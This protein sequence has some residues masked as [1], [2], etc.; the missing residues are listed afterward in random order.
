MRSKKKGQG[1]VEF[2]LILPVLILVFFAIIDGAFVIQGLLTVNHA[3][4]QAARFA[5]TYQPVTG[6]C[7]EHFENGM[8]DDSVPW[9]PSGNDQNESDAAYYDRRTWLIKKYAREQAL[10]LRIQTDCTDSTNINACVAQ[11]V[12]GLFGTRVL[13]FMTF[14][15]AELAD[16]TLQNDSPGLPG[17]PVQVQ[18]VYHVPLTV[19]ATFLPDPYV[20]VVGTSEMINE[21]VQAGIGAVPPPVGGPAPLPNPND[22]PPPAGPTAT[23]GPTP[24]P[25]PTVDPSSPPDVV[26]IELNFETALNMLPQKREHLVI[27]TIKQ[28]GQPIAGMPIEFS[29]DKGSFDYSGSEIFQTEQLNTDADGK[30]RVMIYANEPMVANIMAWTDA[31]FNTIKEISEVDTAIKTWQ[32]TGP[33]LVASDHNPALEDVIA[34]AL[35]DHEP[36]Q[37][38][39]TL[40]WCTSNEAPAT[41]PL[42]L[43][44]TDN[45][46]VDNITWD[47]EITN[48]TVPSDAVG[49]YY[50]ESHSA[51]GACGATDWVARSAVIT[52]KEVMPDL[53]ILDVQVI[54]PAFTELAPG[55]W[56]TVAVEIQNLQP[57]SVTTGPFDVDVYPHLES[58]PYVMQL[59]AE[60]QWLDDLGPGATRVLTFVVAVQVVGANQLWAQIDTSNYVEEIDETNNVWGPLDFAVCEGSDDFDNGLESFWIE[61]P[62]GNAAGAYSIGSMGE[63]KMTYSASSGLWGYSSHNLAYIYQ[64][65]PADK[66][67][68]AR[69]QILEAPAGNSWAK[70]GLHIRGGINRKERFVHNVA[71]RGP[72]LQVASDR[73]YTNAGARD[74]S[75]PYWARIVRTGQTYKFYTS[76]ATDPGAGDWNSEGEIEKSHALPLVGIAHAN[77]NANRADTGRVDNFIICPQEFEGSG[78]SASASNSPPP[79]FTQCEELLYVRSF[80]GNRDTVFEY[81]HAGGPG[82]YRQTSHERY[83][84]NFSIRM[85]ASYGPY[86][87]EQNNY[88]PYLYQDIIIPTDVYSISTLMVKGHYFVEPSTLQCSNGEI[89]PVDKLSLELRSLDG[90]TIIPAQEIVN[91]GVLTQTWHTIPLTASTEMTLTDYAGQTLRLYWDAFHNEDYNG[92]FFYVD[93]VSAQV[94]TQWPIPA[95]EPGTVS[96]G[97]MLSTQA[98]GSSIRVPLPGAEVWAYTQSGETYHTTSIHDG[99]YHFY[100]LPQAGTYIV[101]SEAL[102]DGELR[103]AA[104]DVTLALNDRIYTINLFLQ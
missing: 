75:L 18:V 36:D 5:T 103:T 97:G 85:H 35:R 51:N 33:Y 79:G 6:E 80:E 34:V 69:L 49:T 14:E 10:G 2:A 22:D 26:T 1:L 11:D 90:N 74:I 63:L 99:T 31:N 71:G 9:C 8:V 70:I 104:A 68:D 42:D 60:K 83:M 82:G 87:C 20:R 77:Y 57:V 41:V 50:V 56:M 7:Y 52:I 89:D 102:V 84:G 40:R 62:I 96:F 66:N 44:L 73:G 92:T 25:E 86:P 24:T 47:Y 4:R 100:N 54:E 55:I 91:G 98:S 29:T 12:S 53:T 43:L 32:A 15:A 27:A 3:A 17:L 30:A 46:L 16:A 88:D 67:F 93:D 78:G 72:K 37:N 64:P 38:P 13:G 48:I 65:Y 94:C 95:D 23:P 28:A 76:W 81:W 39:Y 21:G 58:P 61:Q 45:I 59:S 101:Y 19:F